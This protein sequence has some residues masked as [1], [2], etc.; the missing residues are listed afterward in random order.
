M[1][2]RSI[3]LAAGAAAVSQAW[4]G[5][6]QTSL[7]T[8]TW[9]EAGSL[10]TRELPDGR[11]MKVVSGDGLHSP[12]VSSSGRWLAYRNRHDRLSVARSDGQSGASLEGADAVWFPRDDRL[13]VTRDDDVSVFAPEDGW[14]SPRMVVKGAGLPVFGPDGERFVFVRNVGRVADKDD[15]PAAGQLC[16]ASVSAPNRKPEVLVSNSGSLRPFGW[17]HDG[18]SILYWCADDWSASIWNDGVGLNSVSVEGG[19]ARRLG[20]ST[21]V[22]DDIVDLAPK[23]A[24]NQLAV[25]SGDGRAT[26]AGKRI[27]VVDLKTGSSRNVTMEDIAAICPAWAPDGRRIAY[28]AAPDA[29]VAYKKSM[30]GAN[31][32]IM[33]GDGAVETKVVT[34]DMKVA[35]GGGEP[36]HVFLHQRKI[37]LLDASGTGQPRQLTSDPRYRDEEPLWSADGRHILFGRMDY[38]GHASLWLMESSGGAPVEVCRLQISDALG[39]ETSWFGFYGYTDWRDAFDWR[40]HS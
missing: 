38:D 32:R 34:R 22:H 30:A 14:K 9:V 10:W 19:Q 11:A 12:R 8:L 28:V 31:I 18:K 35:P 1:R 3:L 29:E 27:A 36:A 37:W 40:W 4:K 6:A 24:G 13:A 25:T 20:V 23:S 2:R 39:N 16:L 5:A 15:V 21:L 7:G 33:R 26:W 17:T